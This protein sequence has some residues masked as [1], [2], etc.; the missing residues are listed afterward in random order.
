MD[1]PA[2]TDLSVSVIQDYP[3]RRCT[4]AI[5]P[6]IYFTTKFWFKSCI[7]LLDI[8]HLEKLVV[9]GLITAY[10]PSGVSSKHLASVDETG[11][12]ENP[13]RGD[14][15]SGQQIQENGLYGKRCL[16][17]HNT[18]IVSLKILMLNWILI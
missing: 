7:S 18:R 3:G 4:F 1:F 5:H 14:P 13:D 10:V 12:N 9:S 11:L 17:Y 15:P 2:A 8:L 16:W 6:S